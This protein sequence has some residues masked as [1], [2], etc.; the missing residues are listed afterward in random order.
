LAVPALAIVELASTIRPTRLTAAA[1]VMRIPMP[2]APE[3]PFRRTLDVAY[4]VADQVSPLIR[5]VVADNPG[6]FTHRGTGT[7]IVGRGEVAVIDPGPLLAAHVE[8][9]A[10]ALDGERIAHILVTHTHR[11]H[12]PASRPLQAVRGGVVAAYGRHGAGRIDRGHKVEEGADLD[13]APDVEVR[14]GDEIAGDGWTLG[15][16]HT[17][18]HTSNHICYYLREERA[19]FTGDHVMGWSTTIVSPPDG[20]MAQYVDSLAH[21][22][23]RDDQIYWP[24][25]GPPVTEPRPFVGALIA[26][27]NY[28]ADQIR[29]C[30]AT[31]IETIAE[32]VPVI[33]DGLP[34][35]MRGAAGRSVFATLIDMVE[36]GEAQCAGPF[37][38][39]ARYALR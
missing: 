23:G 1:T 7:Y 10:A 8:A 27:R 12:S 16:V 2:P 9:M 29:H 15:C 20:D 14:H 17:P 21:L 37:S 25:H 4:G 36:R 31:G 5:R 19:L 39:A 35:G 3:I 32:M 18:G 30:L 33:Y 34:E 13:F 24:T 38:I 28:R 22:H 11:D 6:P 26:H